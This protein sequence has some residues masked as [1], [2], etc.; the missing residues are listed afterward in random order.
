MDATP[1]ARPAS[2]SARKITRLL[3]NALVV[4][5]ALLFAAVAVLWVCGCD[6]FYDANF[7]IERQTLY[8]DFSAS[9]AG[10]TVY[11][12]PT[13][14]GM[15]GDDGNEWHRFHFDVGTQTATKSK[16]LRYANDY[17]YDWE[18]QTASWH[19]RNFLRFGYSKRITYDTSAPTDARGRFA[20]DNAEYEVLVPPW[21]L[22]LLLAVLP[23][24]RWRV[25]RLDR[26]RRRGKCSVCGYDLRATPERCPE[27]GSVP[28]NC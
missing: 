28:A 9:A 23:A 2:S 19:E 24:W 22:L 17:R 6:R 11:C 14:R 3:F 13:A 18:N 26:R 5:S 1:T 25:T 8:M 21:F 4:V 27:C 20:V 7:W 12:L 16:P 10:L 15:M